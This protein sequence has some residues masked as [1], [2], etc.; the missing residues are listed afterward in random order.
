MSIPAWIYLIG[1]PRFDRTR[2]AAEPH[3]MAVV[4]ALFTIFWLSAFAAQAA[5][6]TANQC[7]TACG[8]SK[9][10]VG[11]GFFVTYVAKHP[12]AAASH[13]PLEAKSAL[14]AL[15][16]ATP[17]SLFFGGSS[18][19]SFYTL[20]F[21]QMNGRLPGYDA[22][23]RR[24]QNIDPDKAAFS[25]APHDEEYA[26]VRPNDH[27][28]D[29]DHGGMGA[30][31]SPYEYGGAG[32]STAGSYNDNGYGS[33]AGTSHLHAPYGP[34]SMGRP[35]LNP[36]DDHS[37]YRPPTGSGTAYAPPSAQDDYDDESRP[38]QFPTAHYDRGVV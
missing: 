36:F 14:Q 25:V 37:E 19:V 32:G 28:L 30:A 27:E 24:N 29:P 8:Q 9:A 33:A 11:L 34:D 22:L 16:E 6:N 12:D 15:T 2:K 5:Y 23:Q 13:T 7:G 26:Q 38:V 1:S 31:A 10:I 4:D 3:A 20:H 35:E 18:F 17:H 21:Y